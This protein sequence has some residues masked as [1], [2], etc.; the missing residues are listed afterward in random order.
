MACMYVPDFR[1]V[2]KTGSVG[3]EVMMCGRPVQSR[4]PATGKHYYTSYIVNST[5]AC[6]AKSSE[7]FAVEK[8][9]KRESKFEWFNITE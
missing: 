6:T 3:A 7:S 5:K 2:Q 1:R 4:L 9:K 8:M